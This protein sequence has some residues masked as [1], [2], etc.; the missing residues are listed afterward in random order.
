MYA[1]KFALCAIKRSQTHSKLRYNKHSTIILFVSF[2]CL[3][4][5]RFNPKKDVLSV[6]QE[7]PDSSDFCFTS[8]FR[9]MYFV[10]FHFANSHD[11]LTIQSSSQNQAT[12]RSF[13]RIYL[14]VL[15]FQVFYVCLEIF[16]CF[17]FFPSAN[18]EFHLIFCVCRLCWNVMF[19]IFVF[20]FWKSKTKLIV[21]CS[22][23]MF[24]S[25]NG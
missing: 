5:L 14:T 8:T 7:I 1:T 12:Q 21:F 3:F 24:C 15:I 25:R 17:F 6:N 10:H 13:H 9:C 22:G 23:N 20:F 16:K 11:K 19:L 2:Y 18:R 4:S